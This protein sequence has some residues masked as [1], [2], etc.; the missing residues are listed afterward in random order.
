MRVR[1][2]GAAASTAVAEAALPVEAPVTSVRPISRARCSAT[3]LARSLNEALGLRPSSLSSS[4]CSS[5][6][7]RPSR[8]A[9]TSGVPPTGGPSSRPV[10]GSSGR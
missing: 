1:I 2:P 3:A 9:A 4:G 5:P 7:S 8:G 6:S 10:T